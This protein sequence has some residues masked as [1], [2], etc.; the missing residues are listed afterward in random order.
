MGAV[1]G[2]LCIGSVSLFASFMPLLAIS[3]LFGLSLSIVTSATSAFIADLSRR[4][5][6]GSAMGVL[7]SIMDIG[8][9]TGPLVSGIVVTYLGFGQAFAVAS[10]VLVMA[11]FLFW[12]GTMVYGL[13]GPTEEVAR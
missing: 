4:E 1:I 6:H 2:A 9:T 10:F 11:A 8:H 12:L 3:I 7:G 13:A 5:T